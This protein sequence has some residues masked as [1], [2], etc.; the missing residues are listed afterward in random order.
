MSDLRC[1]IHSEIHPKSYMW[2]LFSCR[3]IEFCPRIVDS[4]CDI[5]GIIF[6]ACWFTRIVV[7]RSEIGSAFFRWFQVSTIPQWILDL[8]QI[9]YQVVSVRSFLLPRTRIR[10]VGS[11]ERHRF[12]VGSAKFG[13]DHLRVGYRS[14]YHSIFG[15]VARKGVWRRYIIFF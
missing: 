8:R 6:M 9:S 13:F 1:E 10:W 3:S 15:G 14:D 2:Q 7:L 12:L 5:L 11:P 4:R